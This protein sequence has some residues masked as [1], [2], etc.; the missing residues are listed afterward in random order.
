MEHREQ[1]G[2]LIGAWDR[3]AVEI[4]ALANSLR[5]AG[6]YVVIGYDAKAVMP[7]ATVVNSCDFFFS[8]GIWRN[9][10]SGHLSQ[11][12]TG[13]AHLKERGYKYTLSTTGDALIAKPGGIPSLVNVLDDQNVITCHWRDQCGT[14]TFFG[15]TAELLGVYL[16]IPTGPPQIERKF[17]KALRRNHITYTIHPCSA[18]D[19]GIWGKTIGFQ[20][21]NGNYKP[22]IL[23]LRY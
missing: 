6:F 11:I 22:P 8:G 18:E 12:Q 19:L 14:N 15:K 9:K 16:D 20:R 13:L 23:P 3:Y 10:Q 7:S 4:G 1:I 2:I 21:G 17:R 5:D